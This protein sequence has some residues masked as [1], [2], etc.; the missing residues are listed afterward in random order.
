MRALNSSQI[1][2]LT[3]EAGR[4][5]DKLD[6]ILRANLALT[7]KPLGA[8]RTEFHGTLE[9]IGEDVVKARQ[10]GIPEIFFDLWTSH[11]KIDALDDWLSYTDKLWAIA[12]A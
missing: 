6:L 5:P 11:P 1:Q 8:D 4:D 10:A 2:A 3:K 7:D 9:Q 12:Q